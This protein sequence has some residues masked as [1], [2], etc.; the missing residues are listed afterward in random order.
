MIKS[1]F[2]H[3]HRILAKLT[4]TSDMDHQEPIAFMHS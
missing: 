3:G 4:V 2:F 1:H